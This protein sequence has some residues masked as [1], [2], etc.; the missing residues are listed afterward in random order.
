MSYINISQQS[1]RSI[2]TNS[3]LYEKPSSLG[4][5]EFKLSWLSYLMATP[6]P[7]F[8]LVFHLSDL[9]MLRKLFFSTYVY[10]LGISNLSLTTLNVLY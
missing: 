3:H 2:N 10:S 4:F 9:S 5:Q 8:L 6:S 1:E 7:L